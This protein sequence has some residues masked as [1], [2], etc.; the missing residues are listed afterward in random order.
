MLKNFLQTSNDVQLTSRVKNDACSDSFVELCRRYENVYYKIC[1]RYTPALVACGLNPSDIY[2]EKDFIMYHCARTFN[3]EKKAKFSTWVG[4]Y[5]RYLCLN[6]INAKRF[7]IPTD[8]DDLQRFVEERQAKN[9]FQS[10]ADTGNLHK[11]LHEVLDNIEDK[12]ISSIIKMRYLDG[13][14]KTHW[15]E[16]AKNLNISSQTAIHLHH[17]GMKLIQRKLNRAIAENEV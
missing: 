16:I 6:S 13:E 2:K 3:P 11:F 17:R 14:K 15:N 8:S 5:A 9:D 7:I 4:N 1:Q 12:R 10:S